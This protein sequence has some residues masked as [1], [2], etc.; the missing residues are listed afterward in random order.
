MVDLSDKEKSYPLELSGGEQQ[1]VSMARAMV[2][3]P[4]ILIADEPTGNL[5]PDT[6][7][8]VMN[9]LIKINQSGT[10]V[11]MVTHSKEIVNSIRK[12]SYTLKKVFL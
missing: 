4:K 7:W 12:G 9:A 3:R 11:I 8:D 2:N 5:D 1:R 10:T 6:S